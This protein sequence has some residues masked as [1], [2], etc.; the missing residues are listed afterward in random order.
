VGLRHL[1]S[2]L[3]LVRTTGGPDGKP[4]FFGLPVPVLGCSLEGF[5]LAVE[6]QNGNVFPDGTSLLVEVILREVLEPDV[7]AGRAAHLL[8]WRR[9]SGEAS[10]APAA[11]GLLSSRLA[12][13]TCQKDCCGQK[14]RPEIRKARPAEKGAS[15]F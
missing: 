13:G 1:L 14:N 6:L 11:R 3:L 9:S 5:L 7:V 2:G 15:F 12:S 10:R 8:G 4:Q